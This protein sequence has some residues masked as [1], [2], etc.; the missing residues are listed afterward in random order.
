M[1][2]NP[3]GFW[4]FYGTFVIGG[5][6]VVLMMFSES[7]SGI[8]LVFGLAIGVGNILGGL[9]MLK[10][11]PA[12]FVAVDQATDEVRVRRWG[13]LGRSVERY[14]L[15]QVE[16]ATVETSEHTDG[17]TVFRP[18]LLLNEGCDPVPISRFWYQSD[19]ASRQVT[20]EIN[21]FLS[22]PSA[23]QPVS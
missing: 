4:I 20:E 8:R 21:R 16:R 12:S 19:G 9:L 17:G 7:V 11:E 22:R 3:F 18:T 2:D 10:R 1:R 14:S 23:D 13:L 5:C 6:F 15:G